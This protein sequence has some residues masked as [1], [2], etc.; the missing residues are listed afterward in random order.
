M[1]VEGTNIGRDNSTMASV[2][3]IEPFTQTINGYVEQLIHAYSVFIKCSFSP[4]ERLLFITLK[5][6]DGDNLLYAQVVGIV[7]ELLSRAE[8]EFYFNITITRAE[9]FGKL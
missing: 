9:R 3:C 5:S 4:S 2:L 8:E 1:N 6:V 7:T